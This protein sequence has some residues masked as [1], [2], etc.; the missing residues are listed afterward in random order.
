M[1]VKHKKLQEAVEFLT[2]WKNWPW[3]RMVTCER[4]IVLAT[5]VELGLIQGRRHPSG[6]KIYKLGRKF[7]GRTDG[8]KATDFKKFKRLEE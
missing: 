6:G 7:Y 3:H 8:F 1:K 2:D 4:E 5:L